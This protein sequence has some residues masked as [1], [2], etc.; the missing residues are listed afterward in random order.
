[1]PYRSRHGPLVGSSAPYLR[2]N[3]ETWT[4]YKNTPLEVDDE[5]EAWL[6]ALSQKSSKNQRDAELW[7]E[8]MDRKEQRIDRKCAAVQGELEGY[9]KDRNLPPL[10]PP[11]PKSS[12]WIDINFAR[13]CK[14]EEMRPFYIACEEG[15][16]RE[17]EKWVQEKKNVLRQKGIQDGLACAVRANQVHVARYLLEDGGAFVHGAVVKFA[18]RNL[19]LPLLKLC[20]EHGYH[21]NQ[22][23]PSDFGSYGTALRHCIDNDD[24]VR[25]LLENGAD[26][27]LSSFR[28]NRLL[29]WQRNNRATPPMDRISGLP[30]DLA[31]ASG[32]L[33][34]VKMLLEHGAQPKFSRPFCR[35]LGVRRGRLD[36]RP[37][38]E[39][40]WRALIEVLLRYGADINGWDYERGTVQWAAVARKR[41]DIVEFLLENGAK[42]HGRRVAPGT[43]TDK[44]LFALAAEGAGLSWEET[45]GLQRYLGYLSERMEGNDVD[46]VTPPDGA[47]D[48]PLIQLMLKVKRT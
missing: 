47:E 22:Q 9:F 24:I 44:S 32:S 43:C 28:D 6:Q 5:D 41:W 48:N 19:S 45:D 36:T 31:V 26:P 11:L 2:L 14:D 21:P 25:L 17:V 42:T 1:M 13:T 34:V 40:D 18:C 37:D 27:N 29:F 16:L 15:S 10:P 46:S 20:V 8:I 39:G 35:I 3:R 33:A 23:I 4:A 38:A 7:E 30:L 12:L